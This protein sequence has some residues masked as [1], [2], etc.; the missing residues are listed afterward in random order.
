MASIIKFTALKIK[1]EKNHCAP[2]AE[3]EITRGC[4]LLL[5]SSRQS[6]LE[7]MGKH[8]QPQKEDSNA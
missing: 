2:G 8:R 5:K 3:M 7:L 4:Y 6:P 1:Q